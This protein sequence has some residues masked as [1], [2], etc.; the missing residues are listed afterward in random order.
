MHD[1]VQ[2]PVSASCEPDSALQQY[3]SACERPIYDSRLA[4]LFG[5]HALQIGDTHIDLLAQSRIPS[6][7]YVSPQVSDGVLTLRCESEYLPFAENTV[8]VVCMPHHLERCAQPQ[9]TLREVFRVLVPEGSLI[10]TGISPLSLLGMRASCGS[11]RRHGRIRRLFCGFRIRDW[12]NVLG[13]EIVQ[14]GYVMHALP[15]NDAVW[16][17]RQQPLE[18]WGARLH[19][20]TGGIYFMV[21]RKKVLHQRLKIG[22]WKKTP[23]ARALPARKS[24]S[25][26]QTHLKSNK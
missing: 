20:L 7:H 21:A 12:L 26:K 9:Q 17:A 16:L 6:K 19:G 18:R 1:P 8:D 3:I 23:V 11:F 15:I 13:F 4:N 22:D 10:M 2:P 5:Y 25:G 14:S 24:H